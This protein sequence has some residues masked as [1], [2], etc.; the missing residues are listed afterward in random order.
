MN[1][2]IAEAKM[3]VVPTIPEKV[4]KNFLPNKP[5]IRKLNKGSKTISDMNFPSSILIL[6]FIGF[7]HI[8]G[9]VTAIKIDDDCYCYCG[10]CCCDDDDEDG[11]EYAI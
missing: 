4:L 6:H 3:E 11:K 5:R 1:P 8:N 7:I 10:F 2:M 9:V